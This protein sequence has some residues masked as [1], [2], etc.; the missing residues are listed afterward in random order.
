MRARS[1][2]PVVWARCTNCVSFPQR[3]H[4]LTKISLSLT[5]D[6]VN[7]TKLGQVGLPL[8]P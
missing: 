5:I 2:Y 1:N 3:D 6:L 8:C 7:P 4:R